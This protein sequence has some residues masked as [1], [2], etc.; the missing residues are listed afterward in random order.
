MITLNY[1]TAAGKEYPLQMH[2]ELVAPNNISFEPEITIEM[3]K[4]GCR[5]Y[6]V[7][8]GCPPRAPLFSTLVQ[9][10]NQ[11]L[12]IT[13]KFESIYKP[14]KVLNSQNTAIHWKFQDGILA[15][16][17]NRLGRNLIFKLGGTFLA[18]GY[19]MGCPGK[20][21]TF[22]LGLDQCRNPHLRTYS[23]EAT[24][25]NVVK[26]VKNVFGDSM[27][28]YRK[29]NFDVPY[30]LK[31]V[32]FIPNQPIDRDQLDDIIHEVLEAL[33]LTT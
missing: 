33:K 19:C 9:N 6:G 11:I 29:G 30:M 2:Y 17:L 3:C 20:K 27:Y 16:V 26:T 1:V 32:A 31:C 25:I 8:G 24:G 22:K 28:W 23:M 12:L 14:E 5:N 13:C 15:R 7:S 18:T 4:N 10:E 21:C